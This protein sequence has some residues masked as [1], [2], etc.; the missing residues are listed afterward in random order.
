[1]KTWSS[2]SAHVKEMGIQGPFHAD[3]EHE[4]ARLTVM[5]DVI[6]DIPDARPSPSRRTSPV[7][8]TI[9]QM[10]YAPASMPMWAGSERTTYL[11]HISLTFS[12]GVKHI[13]VDEDDLI[14]QR[15]QPQFMFFDEAILQLARLF[16]AECCAEGPSDLLYGDGLGTALLAR[17]AWLDK[18]TPKTLKRGGLSTRQLRLVTAYMQDRL[19]S[20]ISLAELA[21]MIGM[22][23]SYFGRAFR[24]STGESPHRWLMIKRLGKACEYLLNPQIT[25]AE[26]A[27]LTGFSHQAHLTRVFRQILGT[28]PNAW[29]RFRDD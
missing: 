13:A 22:S 28:T 18:S 17:L 12:N 10:N 26:I 24:T 4:A 14:A 21:G 7:E 1:M 2:I 16:C 9:H 27:Q 29:R 23:R 8:N 20:Q 15:I 11:S 19:A 25:I 3:L 5:L 6:G